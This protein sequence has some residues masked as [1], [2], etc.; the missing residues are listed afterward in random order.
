MEPVIYPYDLATEKF[1]SF[2]FSKRLH[3]TSNA[4]VNFVERAYVVKSII[5]PNAVSHSNEEGC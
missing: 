2:I 3:L 5:W 1:I 4:Q